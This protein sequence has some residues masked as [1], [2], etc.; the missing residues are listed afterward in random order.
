MY[1]I[2]RPSYSEVQK[3]LLKGKQKYFR[4]IFQQKLFK[5]CSQSLYVYIHILLTRQNLLLTCQNLFFALLTVTDTFY[6]YFFFL[7]FFF[8][9]EN[10]KT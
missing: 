5:V 1:S 7:Q 3:I 8:L 6:F 10:S 2:Q 9:S 4:I